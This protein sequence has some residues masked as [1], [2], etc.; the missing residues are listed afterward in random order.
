MSKLRR[1]LDMKYKRSLESTLV[2]CKKSIL[3]LGPRQTGKSTLLLNLKP[4][5]T[6]NLANEKTFLQFSAQA[7]LLENILSQK[8]YKTVFI[9]EVQRIPSI[10]NTIQAIIDENPNKYKF[11]LS[12]SSARKLKRGNANLLP[13]RLVSFNLNPLNLEELKFKYNL[14]KLLALGCLPGILT[15]QELKLK[16]QLLM[17]YSATY[18]KEE[19]QA[20]ALT[21]NIEGFSRFLYVAASKNGQFIDFTKMSSQAGISQ[22]TASRFFEILEDTLIITRINS[23]AKNIKFIANELLSLLQS[24]FFNQNFSNLY[25][26]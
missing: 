17:T 7:D 25:C 23:F 21:K 26:I 22:K 4:E 9:D 8:K 20:E 2:S 3:L 10:L 16:K 1:N 11:L 12:G 14:N 19:I 18:L 6:I 5:L 13:G 24:V 15:E